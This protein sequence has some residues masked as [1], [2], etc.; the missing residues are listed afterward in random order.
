MSCRPIMEIPG[1]QGVLNL[2]GTESDCL[3]LG[4]F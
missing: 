2:V 4:L 3:R 1:F